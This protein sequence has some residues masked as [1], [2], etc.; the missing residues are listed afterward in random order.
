[1]PNHHATANTANRISK[2]ATGYS[3]RKYGRN[4][5][6]ANSRNGLNTNSPRDGLTSS[7]LSGPTGTANGQIVASV[8]R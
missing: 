5:T 8:A 1:M 3:R 4:L 6:P 2:G 7:A